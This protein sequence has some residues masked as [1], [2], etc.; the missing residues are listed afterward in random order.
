MTPTGTQQLLNPKE[1]ALWTVQKSPQL[2]EHSWKQNMP[3]VMIFHCFEFVENVAQI[4][5]QHS[6][7]KGWEGLGGGGASK[8]NALYAEKTD[9][10]MFDKFRIE[11]SITIQ[12]IVCI[13]LFTCILMWEIKFSKVIRSAK[14][15]IV[16]AKK[17]LYEMIKT[18]NPT[19]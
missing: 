11:Y 18:V 2:K 14:L 12:Y 10:K 7:R 5:A 4:A 17:Q 3:T 9:M 8:K 19:V 13:V 6:L 15:W 16:N 1:C